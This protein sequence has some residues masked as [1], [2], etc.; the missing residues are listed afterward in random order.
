MGRWFG[1][2]GAEA[3]EEEGS[4]SDAEDGDDIFEL[5][6]M[7]ALEI[8]QRGAEANGGHQSHHA[9]A[10]A[11]GTGA[12]GWDAKSPSSKDCINRSWGAEGQP[13]TIDV[14]RCCCCLMM[15][16]MGPLYDPSCFHNPKPRSPKNPKTLNHQTHAQKP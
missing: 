2:A 8:A 4:D 5:E 3:A 13:P 7:S 1:K 9:E 12:A 11:P 15:T 6:G 14:V 16:P 10:V